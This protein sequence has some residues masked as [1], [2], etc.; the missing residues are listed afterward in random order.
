MEC[1]A[2]FAN[3]PNKIGGRV[4]GQGGFVEGAIRGNEIL[5]SGMNIGEVAAAAAG[6]LDF[7]SD[8]VVMF[9]NCHPPS[10]LSSLDRAHQTGCAASDDDHVI[11]RWFHSYM[12]SNL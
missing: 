2:V 10:A 4:A 1:D 6:D 3:E 5:G 9:E 8:D 12:I 7:P 11:A